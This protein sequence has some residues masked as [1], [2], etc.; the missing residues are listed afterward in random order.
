M[1]WAKILLLVC[2]LPELAAYTLKV[3][4]NGSVPTGVARLSDTLRAIQGTNMCN[5]SRFAQVMKFLANSQQ[6]SGI[7]PACAPTNHHSKPPSLPPPP[8][9]FYG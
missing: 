7:V 6:L 1:T 8:P 9:A 3:I 4:L 2:Y 5:I